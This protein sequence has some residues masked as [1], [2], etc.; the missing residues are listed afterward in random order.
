VCNNRARAHASC[1]LKLLIAV[2]CDLFANFAVCNLRVA[3]QKKNPP[4]TLVPFARLC[5]FMQKCISAITTS[6]TARCT[7]C[8]KTELPHGVEKIYRAF[9]FHRFAL[10]EEI[11][12]K[13][14]VSNLKCERAGAE[15][16]KC[17][18][19]IVSCSK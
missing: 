7:L 5:V 12:K 6:P 1:A 8:G 16:R 17:Q 14:A 3:V 4:R 15:K 9:A 10:R 13:G 19:V 18:V 11:L 2:H